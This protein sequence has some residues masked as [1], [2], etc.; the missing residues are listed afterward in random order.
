MNAYQCCALTVHISVLGAQ[1][2]LGERLG[3]IRDA[4][5]EAGFSKDFTSFKIRTGAYKAGKAQ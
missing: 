1:A 5:A 4:Y 3:G 2:D